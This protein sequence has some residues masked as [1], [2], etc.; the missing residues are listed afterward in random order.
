MLLLDPRQQLA[1]EMADQRDGAVAAVSDE[2][3]GFGEE[4]EE[5]RSLPK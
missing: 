3:M 4:M 5:R 2:A 1:P